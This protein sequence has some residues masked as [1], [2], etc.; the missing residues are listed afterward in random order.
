MQHSW[1]RDQEVTQLLLT[2]TFQSA[3]TEF[4]SEITFYSS[5]G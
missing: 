2:L 3:R 1:D 5:E 4:S